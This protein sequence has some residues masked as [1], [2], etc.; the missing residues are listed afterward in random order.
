MEKLFT[1]IEKQLENFKVELDTEEVGSVIKTADGIATV[2]GLEKVMFNELVI[3]DGGITGVVLSILEDEIGVIIFGNNTSIREGQTVRRTKRI[4][5][6]PVGDG[7]LGRVINP[8]GEPLDGL[9]ELTTTKMRTMKN[10]APGVMDRESV[11]EPLQTG[12]K[13]IDALV[14]IGRGQREL[15]IGDRQ[16]GK[17]SAAIDTIINQNGKDV[18]CIYVAIGQKDSTVMGVIETLKEHNAME[19]TIIV[20]APSSDPASMLYIAPYSGM[21]IAEEFMYDGRDVLIVFDD[22]TKQANAYRELSLLLRRPPGREAYPGDVFYLHSRLLELAAKLNSELGGGSI[23]ALPFIETQ[24]NDIAAYIP[25]NVISI[26]DGQIFM[27]S[28][29][30]YSGIRP[31]IDAG[32]SVSRVG[33]SAQIKAMKKVA[34]TLRLDLAA[35][36]ELE[37]FSQFGSDLDPV[38]RSKIERGRRT[39]EVLKQELH[40]PITVELQV[41]ILYALN[42]GFLDAIPITDISRFEKF[43]FQEMTNQYQSLLQV[44]TD[45]K[46]LP[47]LEQLNKA[48][49]AICGDF[50]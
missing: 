30:F 49:T 26:T 10:E 21:T 38:T 34:G 5:E 36:R 19:H 50:I 39:V 44:I 13:A 23:T 42:N 15:I 16:T 1:V 18:I 24:A 7:L 14:P 32:N 41:M 48:L 47:D 3:F 12:I 31:A 27:L 4:I 29:L 40:K 33:G 8:L 28:N 6:L 46:D 22:L 20:S 9:G 11:N 37:A 2:F 17:T 45:T 35:F 25:T 43:L